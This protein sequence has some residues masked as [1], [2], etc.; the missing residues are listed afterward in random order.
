MNTS[1][2]TIDVVKCKIDLMFVN[3]EG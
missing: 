1:K 3:W 2:W